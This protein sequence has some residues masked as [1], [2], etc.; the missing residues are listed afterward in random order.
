MCWRGRN[1]DSQ[2]P[3]GVPTLSS[4]SSAEEEMDQSSDPP[5]QPQRTSRDLSQWGREENQE[6]VPCLKVHLTGLN[7]GKVERQQAVSALP[8]RS[9]PVTVIRP[10]PVLAVCTVFWGWRINPRSA[11][12]TAGGSGCRQRL[13]YWG[14][15]A[16]LLF[17]FPARDLVLVIG[18][19]PYL[20]IVVTFTFLSCWDQNGATKDGRNLHKLWF[21]P[22]PPSSRS[23]HMLSNSW[24]CVISNKF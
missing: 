22:P 8:F 7:Q 24:P 12:A 6:Q 15:S 1:R 16:A 13:P 14:S 23:W 20:A 10:K 19:L 17:L 2:I 3:S 18:R 21:P 4:Q 11:A 5:R 9:S